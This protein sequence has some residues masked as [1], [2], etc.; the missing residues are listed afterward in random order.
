MA[1]R[2]TRDRSLHFIEA[3]AWEFLQ[4]HEYTKIIISFL[5]EEE[6]KKKERFLMVAIIW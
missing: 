4:L 6:W 3:S 5:S 1:C 2:D